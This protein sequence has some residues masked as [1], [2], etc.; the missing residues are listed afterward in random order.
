MGL[1]TVMIGEVELHM[2]DVNEE[3]PTNKAPPESKGS[4]DESPDEA[5]IKSMLE[6]S[7][8]SL[9]KSKEVLKT[10]TNRRMMQLHSSVLAANGLK[11]RCESIRLFVEERCKGVQVSRTSDTT[12]VSKVGSMTGAK[13]EAL[14]GSIVGEVWDCVKRAHEL[15]SKRKNKEEVGRKCSTESIG[16]FRKACWG[17]HET[18]KEG[19]RQPEDKQLC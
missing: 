5:D 7:V 4:S 13:I 15:A 11:E 6:S 8:W 14:V 1:E 12:D 10:V 19:C 3:E 2:P 17:I 18:I 16:A 9:H